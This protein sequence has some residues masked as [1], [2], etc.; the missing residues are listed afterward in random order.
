MYRASLLKHDF[1]G[2]RCG[3][4]EH[5][6]REV[7]RVGRR[8][9]VCQK[10]DELAARENVTLV[11]VDVNIAQNE[12]LVAGVEVLYHDKPH[13]IVHAEQITKLGGGYITPWVQLR[14]K[15]ASRRS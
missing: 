2:C 5:I 4:P 1:S 7:D 10:C 8:V 15:E 9:I 13:R 11:V 6:S 12:A 3:H 14:L